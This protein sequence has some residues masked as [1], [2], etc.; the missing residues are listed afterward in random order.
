M[1]II[2]FVD[3]EDNNAHSNDASMR[4]KILNRLKVSN[5][6]VSI[7]KVI[8][9]QLISRDN[10]CLPIRQ[11]QLTSNCLRNPSPFTNFVKTK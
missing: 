3:A 2:S 10:D 7:Y 8:D 5:N 11:K 4:L 1:F 6:F 9:N